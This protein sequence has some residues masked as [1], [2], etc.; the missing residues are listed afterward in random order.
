MGPVYVR[1]G[2]K[3]GNDYT[4]KKVAQLWQRWQR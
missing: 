2:P 1:T 3:P 4:N